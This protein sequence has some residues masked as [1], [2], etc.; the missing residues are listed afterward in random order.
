MATSLN[1]TGQA[2]LDITAAIAWATGKATHHGTTAYYAARRFHRDQIATGNLQ[3]SFFAFL[4]DAQSS[5]DVVV[6]DCNRFLDEWQSFS[7]DLR[8][9]LWIVLG[10][11]LALSWG[12]VCDLSVIA[13]RLFGRV[14]GYW[15]AQAR[16]DLPVALLSSRRWVA[17]AVQKF[18]VA[19]WANTNAIAR[20]HLYNT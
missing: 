17:V 20:R 10:P 3:K 14:W 5:F 12:A 2:V 7:D 6:D 9:L 11:V 1:T 15:M 4:D 13:A 18:A 19:V 16:Y 8:G